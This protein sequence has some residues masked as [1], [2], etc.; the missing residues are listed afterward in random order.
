MLESLRRDFAYFALADEPAGEPVVDVALER[1]APSY[2]ALPPAVAS[3][4]TPRNVVYQEEGRTIVDYFGRAVAVLERRAGHPSRLTIRGEEDQLVREAVYLF[5]LS[6][7]G[8]HFDRMGLTRIHALG[9]AGA[10]GGVAVM[11]PAGG[12]KSTLAVRALRAEGIRLLSEDSPL[13]DRRGRLHPFPLPIGID[14][15]DVEGVRAEDLRRVERMEFRPKLLLDVEAFAD[16]IEPD[17]QPLRHLVVGRRS[18]AETPSLERI[19]RRAALG[20]LA[21]EAVIG[22]GIYQGME[23][24]LQRGMRDTLAMTPIAVRRARCCFAGLS[25]ARVW[26]LTLS[27]DGER[28]WVALEPLLRSRSGV[29]G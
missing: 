5:L 4:I 13:L 10:A 16:R 11:L 9:L 24:V 22:V 23:F 20:T 19:P 7:C 2:A 25:R 26:Q 28:N 1:G 6:R 12:G 14:D 17:P 15:S 18:L 8:E 3:F 21:R 29:T 27:R